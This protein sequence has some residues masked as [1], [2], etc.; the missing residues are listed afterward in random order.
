MVKNGDS[1][2]REGLREK[3]IGERERERERERENRTRFISQCWNASVDSNDVATGYFLKENLSNSFKINLEDIFSEWAISFREEA[4]PHNLSPKLPKLSLRLC[5]TFCWRE[6]VNEQ[7]TIA[8]PLRKPFFSFS[9]KVVFCFS[10]I[11]RSERR[12]EEVEHL[13]KCKNLWKRFVVV[14]GKRKCESN[15]SRSVEMITR[16]EES[17]FWRNKS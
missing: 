3:E 8:F 10:R 1:V 2:N 4:I 15:S 7:L 17:K 11:I 6:T 13:T 9:Q 14:G 5:R 12:K 16:N